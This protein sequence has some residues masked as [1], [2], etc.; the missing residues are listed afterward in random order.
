[1]ATT[2]GEIWQ[3][4]QRAMPRDQWIGIQ[5]IYSPHSAPFSIGYEE[6]SVSLVHKHRAAA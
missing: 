3:A 4:I 6:L 5:D 1:M 2:L